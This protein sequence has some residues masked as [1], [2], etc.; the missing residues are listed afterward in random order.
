MSG[1]ACQA[2]LLSFPVSSDFLRPISQLP[3][4]F[5]TMRIAAV[6]TVGNGNVV[7]SHRKGVSFMEKLSGAEFT[8]GLD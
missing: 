2:T 3:R 4:I 1:I 5:P 7:A 8:F 6:A